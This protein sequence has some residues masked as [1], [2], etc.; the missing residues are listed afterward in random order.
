ML[1]A[2]LFNAS[3]QYIFYGS[4]LW[5]MADGKDHV[6]I[7][8]T[9]RKATYQRFDKKGAE[10][11]MRP[12]SPAGEWPRSPLQLDD[13]RLLQERRQ[14]AHQRPVWRRRRH[15]HQHRLYQTLQ[16]LPSYTTAY[17]RQPSQSQHQPSFDHQHR[18]LLQTVRRRRQRQPARRN[19]VPVT[20]ATSSHTHYTRSTTSRELPTSR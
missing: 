12:T 1:P 13:R 8:L 15:H 6:K 11:R 2:V 14:L 16:G 9:F 5:T 4:P 3:R 17:K 20:S 10:S 19:A 7:E 18:L